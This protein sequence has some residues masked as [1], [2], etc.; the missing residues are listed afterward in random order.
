VYGCFEYGAV[1]YASVTAVGTFVSIR[2]YYTGFM[3]TT[4]ALFR[5][6]LGF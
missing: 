6:G 1:E 5:R 3:H 2:H 4:K